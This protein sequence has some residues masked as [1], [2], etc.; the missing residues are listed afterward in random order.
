MKTARALG[1]SLPSRQDYQGALA[2]ILRLQKTYNLPTEDVAAGKIYNVT[3][4]SG[5]DKKDCLEI[6][7]MYMDV[8]H[9]VALQ[10][11][12]LLRRSHKLEPEEDKYVLRNMK[13]IYSQVSLIWIQYYI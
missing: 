4:K 6:G 8:D 10:W 9:A 2:A 1:V 11:F 7:K 3:A 12:E 13:Q 5:M